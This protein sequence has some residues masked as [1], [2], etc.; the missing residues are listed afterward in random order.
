MILSVRH[1]I[2]LG[3]VFFYHDDENQDLFQANSTYIVPLQ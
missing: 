2:A 3:D 1:I